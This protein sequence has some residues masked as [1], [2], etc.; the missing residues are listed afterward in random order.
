MACPLPACGEFQPLEWA[1]F[2]FDKENLDTISFA[3]NQCGT[4]SSETAWKE[5]FENASLLPGFGPPGARLPH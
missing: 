2:I 1:Q 5:G 4:V 3:C